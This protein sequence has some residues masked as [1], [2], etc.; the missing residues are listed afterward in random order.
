MYRCRGVLAGARPPS[1]PALAG[2]LLAAF[3]VVEGLLIALGLLVTRVLAQS[4]VQRDEAAFER[5]VL[6][7][8]TTL[9]D[10]LSR[11]G[12]FLGATTTVIA[13][14][15]FGCALLAWRG[16]GPRLPTFL[17]LAVAGETALFVLASLVVH[18]MRPPIPHL[19][20]APPTSSFPSGH[21]AASV[22]LWGGLALG[23][24]RTRPGHRL[25][26]VAV[27]AAVL[28]PLF[29]LLSRLYRGM[30]WPTDVTA[31]VLFTAS[32]L[33]L[34]RALLLPAS[35]T[36]GAAAPERQMNRTFDSPT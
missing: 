12:T 1:W 35:S 8:R 9:L 27:G 21:T 22:A 25:R 32:W 6:A 14:T 17:V 11:G 10:Q 5:T 24:L 7:H 20:P 3:V 16:H 18:R 29:V 2:L 23:L 4:A 13:L 28:L 31:S 33:V 26:N 36:P 34:L 15:V 30:H 19:D